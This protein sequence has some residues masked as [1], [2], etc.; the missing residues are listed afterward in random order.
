M[1]KHPSN[2]S[3]R[4]AAARALTALGDGAAAF[5]EW[6]S[7]A[8][9]LLMS[10]L[11]ACQVVL[12]YFLG[13]ALPWAEEAA[14]YMMVWMAFVGAAIALRRSEHIALTFVA[15]RLPPRLASAVRFASNSLVLAFLML[16]LVLGI[17]L[18]QSV[19]GQRSPALGV[20]MMWPYLI[21]PLGCFF[22]VLEMIQRL[23]WSSSRPQP[24]DQTADV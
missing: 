24:T 23:A 16:V 4:P 10:L 15:D 1:H 7:V 8:S 22:M 9:L 12:R 2:G 11:V 21:L 5:A 17:Q 6:S 13:R 20:N 14:V 19:S 18:A 3:A